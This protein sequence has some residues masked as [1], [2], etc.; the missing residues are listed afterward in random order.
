MKIWWLP[1]DKAVEVTPNDKLFINRTDDGYEIC[2]DVDGKTYAIDFLQTA[3][4]AE[5][6]LQEWIDYNNNHNKKAG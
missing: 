6:R 3:A 4:D 5:K 2:A 1:T